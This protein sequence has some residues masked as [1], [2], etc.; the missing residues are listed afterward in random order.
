MISALVAAVCFAGSV[1]LAAVGDVMLGRWVG[2]RIERE[3]ADV[4]FDSV[5]P[6]LVGADL[7]LGNL[8]C[9][10]SKAPFEAKKRILLRASPT[11]ASAVAKAGFDAMSVANNHALDCG[12]RGLA[13]T[14]ESLRQV[15][16]RSVG[17]SGEPVVFVVNGLKVALLAFS[18]YAFPPAAGTLH[19]LPGKDPKVGDQAAVRLARR[20]ADVVVVSWHWGVEGSARETSRQRELAQATAEAGADVILGHHPHVLQP[21]RWINRKDGR[22]CLV[23]YSLGNFVF[24]AVKESERR[25]MILR[26]TLGRAGAIGFRTRPYRIRNGAPG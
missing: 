26:V 20:S 16:V 6:E 23:A 24:D 1:E 17:D 5:R 18:E 9:V 8:E 13:D 14:L 7:T 12:A 10:L 2:R 15:G 25:T 4:L 22:R 19:T 11:V 21:I 3:G